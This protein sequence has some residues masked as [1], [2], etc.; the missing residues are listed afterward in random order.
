MKTL[1]IFALGVIICIS[2][3]FS[4]ATA[5]LNAKPANSFYVVIGA[6][7]IQKNAIRFTSSSD[8]QQLSAKFELNVQRNL[9]YVYVL[10]TENR[11]KAIEEAIR[12]RKDSLYND[13]WVYNGLLGQSESV[14]G[15]DIN[16][17][18]EETI[19]KV[20]TEDSPK[21]EEATQA[22]NQAVA[23]ANVETNSNNGSPQNEVVTE[24]V[25][26]ENLSASDKGGMDTGT[27]GK[28][29]YFKIFRT[30]DQN[31]VEGDVN[32]IDAERSKKLGTFAGNKQVAISE[33]GNKEGQVS[34]V[35]EVFGFR[36][37]QRDIDFQTPEGEGIQ[38]N[39]SNAT[40]VPFELVRL[41]KGD[42]AVMYNVYFFKD[43]AIMR[44][45]S[46]YEVTSL[47]D[48]L[49]ENPK[50]KIKIHGHTNGGA[51]GK[52]ISLKPDSDNFF[53]LNNTKEGIGSAKELSEERAE[54][55][56]SFLV[57]NGIEAG[58]MQ[59]KAWGGKKPIQDKHGPQAQSNVRVEIEIL[60]N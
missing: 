20:K 18:T 42:I 39:E 15:T 30:D 26:T 25:K 59:I 52:I 8:Q 6:F 44:P 2:S 53:A 46:R 47:L 27:G 28:N 14:T 49:K 9:Y 34:L 22:T 60:E 45:E 11:E 29:F 5:N 55:I 58:R 16:P 13:T 1:N 23:I 48:M 56:Q 38:I 7:S 3:A 12:L 19:S 50:Y 35:C 17:A 24:E 54:V 31:Q 10:S 57:S 43:A 21:T 32:V 40:V 36:K 4:Q 51:H 41:Q 33:P 37:V